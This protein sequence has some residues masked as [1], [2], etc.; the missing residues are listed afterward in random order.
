MDAAT[1]Q[2]INPMDTTYTNY[3]GSDVA[4]GSYDYPTNR[5][6]SEFVNG[7]CLVIVHKGDIKVD[8]VDMTSTA[9]VN[10]PSF[11]FHANEEEACSSLDFDGTSFII[12]EDAIHFQFDVDHDG[13]SFHGRFW[14][15]LTGKVNQILVKKSHLI[16][17]IYLSLIHHS[18]DVRKSHNSQHPLCPLISIQAMG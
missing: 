1:E 8:V 15:V 3:R 14:I 2:T 18:L 7:S 10:T 11:C 12:T 9:N 4:L 16:Q 6:Y 17:S 5:G 13:P